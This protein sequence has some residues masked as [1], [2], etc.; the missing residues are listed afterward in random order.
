MNEYIYSQFRI[1]RKEKSIFIFDDANNLVKKIDLLPENINEGK[2][3]IPLSNICTM[4]CMYCSEANYISE[5]AKITD[6]ED[7]Y[8]II[9][10]YLEYIKYHNEI[11]NVKLSFDYGGEPV[12]QL[13]S[14]ESISSYFRNACYEHDKKPIIQLTTNCAWDESLINRVLLSADQIIV[15]IDGG[16]ELHEK[17]RIHRSGE[18]V[19]STILNNSKLIFNNQ[20]MKQISS[21]VT[22]DTVSQI[23][24]YIRFF[25]EMFPNSFLKMSPVIVT[26]AAE[27]N[28]IERISFSEW[29]VFIK[30]VRK[31]AKGRLKILDTKPE[32]SLTTMYLYGCE[33]MRMTN[34]F[35]W[36][37]G[38]ITCCTDRGAETYVIGKL[39]NHELKMETEIMKAFIDN[40][41]V[42]NISKCKD[43]LAKYY[44]TGG[45]P[46]FRDGKLNCNR[47][48]EKYAKLLIEKFEVYSL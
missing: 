33:H 21:V 12:C 40:N 9:D 35:Y 8:L 39:D 14:L 23:E 5:G 37:D 28:G 13:N 31:L 47:R 10:T 36:L 32:K 6:V 22:V 42:E 41:Y 19:Y 34:W 27:K 43:C 46:S 25:A 18:S 1:L 16:K 17:Y 7:A 11:Q 26:G 38:K 48:I 15:S 29:I 20:K 4:R 2:I 44:C 24:E 3:N 45:C 30:N